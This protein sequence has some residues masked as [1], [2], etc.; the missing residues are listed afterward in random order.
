M[1]TVL[2]VIAL[3]TL[4][5]LGACK[6][7]L[8]DPVSLV[9]D[10]RFLALV[11]EPAEARPGSEVVLH[12]LVVGPDGQVAE[13]APA[14]WAICTTPRP[15]S[16]NNVVDDQCLFLPQDQLPT[17]GLE[18]TATLPVD[19]C[20]L[21]GPDP[22]PS[23]IG[24]PALR[25]TDPDVTGGFY[26][27]VRALLKN[28]AT[29]TYAS[30]IA[31]PRITCNL[32]DATI[33]VADQFRARYHANTNPVIGRVLI[34]LD[35]VTSVDLPAT[36]PVGAAV[37]FLVRWTPESAET[38]PVFDRKSRALVDHREALR[39]SW[40]ATAGA[41]DHDRT[42]AGEDDLAT[43]S[44]NGWTAPATAGVVHLWAVLRDSR[45]GTDFASF[46]VTVQ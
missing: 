23:P 42:G 3:A 35:G 18:V 12:A 4:A 24:Q 13:D 8:G 46:D 16:Q 9:T 40:F 43:V 6:P 22:P 28:D 39:V 30:S 1:R 17:R 38:Y 15:V 25:P 11:S 20:A 41:F 45:G 31:L 19:G 26:Q 37:T 36:V 27:P 21:F 10:R 7:D 32:P 33:D 5:A 14:S 34:S 2:V 44:P 29:G